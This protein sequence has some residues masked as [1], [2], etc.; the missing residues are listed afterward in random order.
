[1]LR[2]HPAMVGEQH[3]QR[4]AHSHDDRYPEPGAEEDA[5]HDVLCLT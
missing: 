4:V 2:E 5:A 3:L 1:M